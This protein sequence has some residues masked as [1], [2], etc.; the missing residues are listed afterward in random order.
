MSLF[1]SQSSPHDA[2][3]LTD[4]WCKLAK[5]YRMEIRALLKTPAGMPILAL[6]SNLEGPAIYISAGVHGDEAAPPWALLAWAWHN[7]ELLRTKAVILC[8]CMNPEGLKANTR[9]NER[10]VDLNRNFHNKR[11]ALP[12]A[13]HRY[14]EDKHMSLGICLHEDYDAQGCY[15]YAL[16]STKAEPM[17]REVESV[18]QRDPR[19]KIDGMTAKMGI[20][21]RKIEPGSI[22]GPEAIVL[23]EDLGCKATLTFETP[24]EFCLDE[25]LEAHQ[26]FLNAAVASVGQ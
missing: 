4:Q 8:P 17:M 3:A 16:G 19:S 15:V 25:R 2:E 23:R 5:R 18:I 22:L 13:W 14:L 21:K 6:N 7:E 12:A 20:M 26:T 1:A 10:G 11:L 9:A 24:S